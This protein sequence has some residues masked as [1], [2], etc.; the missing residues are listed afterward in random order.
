[1]EVF[2]QKVI[3]EATAAGV[4]SSLRMFC[5]TNSVEY[6]CGAGC[7]GG[8]G[9]SAQ[10]PPPGVPAPA[11]CQL[12]RGHVQFDWDVMLAHGGG[13]GGGGW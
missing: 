2:L 1:M 6:T 11:A 8:S 13:G 10:L 5:A 3:A 12:Q 7:C 4:G 9:G